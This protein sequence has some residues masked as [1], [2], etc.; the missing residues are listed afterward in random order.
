VGI[1]PTEDRRLGT[2]HTDTNFLLGS[3]QESSGDSYLYVA[4]GLRLFVCDKI[5]FG[6]SAEFAVSDHHWADQLYRSEFRWRF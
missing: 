3:F 2:A 5:D 1:A 4:S 6:L